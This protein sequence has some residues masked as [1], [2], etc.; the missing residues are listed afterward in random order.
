MKKFIV[1]GDP[2]KHSLSP[3]L[4]NW[5]F[6]KFNISA[7]YSKVCC[8]KTDLPKIFNQI[9]DD[10]ING[11]NITIPYKEL[12]LDFIDEIN[13]RAQ[14]IGAVNCIKKNNDKLIGYNTDWYGFSQLLV[15]NKIDVLNKEIIIIGAGG[16]SRAILFS[17]IQMGVSNIKVFNRTIL[18]GKNLENEI[19][20]SF[21]LD[22][23][24]NY[25]KQD[26]IIIN[27]TSIGM[28]HDESPL[29]K[30]LINN[31][32]III[33]TIYNPYKTRL[34]KIGDI[35]G[36]KTINGLDMFIFQ[37]VASLELWLNESINERLNFKEIKKYLKEML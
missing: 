2:I 13:P 36:A 28:N 23:I 18:K 4:N 12:V 26:S 11:I 31:K 25:I 7:K 16:V 24:N 19:I 34:L 20:K 27:C 37:A 5:I 21:S 22:D 3:Y 33:D 6:K 14:S 9:K 15:I 30:E 35:I 10:S 1:I 29:L 32:Q 17:L 8:D